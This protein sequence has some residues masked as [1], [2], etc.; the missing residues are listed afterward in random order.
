MFCQTSR[1]G[2]QFLTCLLYFSHPFGRPTHSSI[3]HQS[4]FHDHTVSWFLLYFGP[5]LVLLACNYRVL[6]SLSLYS[7]LDLVAAFCSSIIAYT[8]LRAT[9]DQSVFPEDHHTPTPQP[10]PSA[11]VFKKIMI[12]L[13]RSLLC[14]SKHE[15]KLSPD[16]VRPIR[17]FLVI[18]LTALK[19]LP[20]RCPPH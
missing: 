2:N 13:R 17:N 4:T 9:F 14:C 20:H 3:A 7:T 11:M 18:T 12:K 6:H 15:R 1:L 8:L 10:L 5:S 16:I 19:G